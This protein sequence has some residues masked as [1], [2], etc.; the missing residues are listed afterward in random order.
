VRP[1]AP[2]ALNGPLG[3][4]RTWGWAH[5]SL[6]DVRDVR[7]EHG[8]GISVNDV[9]LTAITG[10]LRTL[11]AEA[12]EPVDRTVRTMV[13]VSRRA[14]DAAGTPDN[15]VSAMFA[16]LPLDIEQPVARL[17][18]VSTQ[19]RH[20]KASH[21]A[22]AGEVLTSV[23]GLAPELVLALSGRIATRLP[24][25]SVNT[26]TTNVPGPPYPLYLCGRRLLEAYP[27]VPLAG[28]VRVGIAIYS[29]DGML[30][31][32]VTGDADGSLDVLVLCRAI[33][34]SMGEL[35]A[36]SRPQPRPRRKRAAGAAPRR[37]GR[38]SANPPR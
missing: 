3:P 37:R 20:L 7:R 17:R 23:G 27:Y 12:G 9:V 2:S 4:H 31:F 26:V 14:R 38:A 30:G 15:R 6:A 13:P 19:L 24:Q 10:G 1:P 5:A 34:A 29:Y 8:E 16:D 21:E 32:G 22:D 28:H 36:A 35:V 33:E 11:L 18:A 25:R